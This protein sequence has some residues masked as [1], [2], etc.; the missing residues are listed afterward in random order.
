MIQWQLQEAKARMSVLVKQAQAAPQGITVHG[1]PVAVLLSQSEFERL[2]QAGGSLLDFVQASPL[3]ALPAQDDTAF[4][5]GLE[6]SASPARRVPR[7]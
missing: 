7:L 6:R 4:E 2:S 1:K 3:A 5:R